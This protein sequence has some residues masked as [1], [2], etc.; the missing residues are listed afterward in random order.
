MYLE[1][2]DVPDDLTD[3]YVDEY[4]ESEDLGISYE[5]FVRDKEI[6]DYG[7]TDEEMRCGDEDDWC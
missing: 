2:D 5:E 3:E 7:W 6:E 1:Y 4:N